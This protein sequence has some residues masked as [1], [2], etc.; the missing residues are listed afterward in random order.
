MGLYRILNIAL[1]LLMLTPSM[2]CI[3][4][5]CPEI[6]YATVE[7]S[8]PPCHGINQK[9]KSPSGPMLIEDC[10]KNDLGQSSTVDMPLP[11]IVFFLFAFIFPVLAIVFPKF[12]GMRSSGADPPPKGRASFHRILIK[13]RILQ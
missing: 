8:M 2:V 10:M 13:Q 9:L 11:D 6:A 4:V 1:M 3:M 5:V 7:K 12:A